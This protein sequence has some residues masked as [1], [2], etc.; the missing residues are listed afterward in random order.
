MF[1]ESATATLQLI[2]CTTTSTGVLIAT[3]QSSTEEALRSQEGLI[4]M[5]R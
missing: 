3:Y 2:D 5:A 4:G 1:D